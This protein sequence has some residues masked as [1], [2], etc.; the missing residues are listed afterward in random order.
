MGRVCVVGGGPAGVRAAIAASEGGAEVAL[1]ER[2]PHLPIPKEVWPSVLAGNEPYEK[3]G[4]RLLLASGVELRM[5]E[6]VVGVGTS[7]L[8]TSRGE[9][10]YDSAV[11][12]TG[13]SP[14]AT[15]LPWRTKEGAHVLDSVESFVSLREDLAG[16]SRMA[17][18]G[19]GVIALDV[20]DALLR[21]G[22]AVTAFSPNG[23]L[24][25]RFSQA[26]ADS[27][28]AAASE[29]GASFVSTPL[30]KVVGARGVEAL[31][32]EDRVVPCDGVVVVP[33][34]KPDPP[35]CGA[36]IGP[37]GGVVVDRHMGS[38][39][40]AVYAAGDCAEFAVGERTI[41]MMA[42][43]VARSTGGVA[44]ANAAGRSVA[45]RPV[46]RISS[47]FLGLNV[48]STG[49]GLS[50]SLYA[51]LDAAESSLR[52]ADCGACS[53]VFERKTGIVLGVQY[54]VPRSGPSVDLLAFAVASGSN[55]A[56]LSTLED[57]GSTDISLVT[58]AAREG[59][60]RCQRS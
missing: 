37:L 22:I 6:A 26:V 57:F 49:L 34:W 8:K 32:T 54:A 5:C 25:T 10:S 16:R 36:R 11:L 46:A 42:A 17:L 29:R 53:I 43:S 58:E 30:Q 13:C 14:V 28:A 51:G 47:K 55:L 12:A 59:M 39:G 3:S 45:L 21:D 35:P 9:H 56:E 23:I 33:R 40:R 1:V 18:L 44:G 2:S 31:L 19:T 4:S 24:G 20:L 60:S 38:S 27:V 15:V 7:R 52:S 48:V 41:P 50:D